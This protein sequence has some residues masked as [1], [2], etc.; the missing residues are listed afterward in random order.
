M[1]GNDLKHRVSVV[2]QAAHQ[3]VVNFIRDF[4]RVQ[5]GE[6]L[7]EVC[8]RLRRQILLQRRHVLHTWMFVVDFAVQKPQ[9]ILFIAALAVRAQLTDAVLEVLAQRAPV[10]CPAFIVAQRVDQYLDLA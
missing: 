1:R 9:R 2:V 8:L 3:L 7:I 10:G 5:G 6:H 4:Q